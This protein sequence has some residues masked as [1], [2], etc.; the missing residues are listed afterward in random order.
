[1]SIGRTTQGGDVRGLYMF[2]LKDANALISQLTDDDLGTAV[3]VNIATHHFR[4]DYTVRPNVQLQNLLFIQDQ[5]RNSNPAASFFVPLGR[6][7]ART[8]R[9]QGQLAF[10]F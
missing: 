1:M 3:G 2:G 10:S 4:V 6:D 9:Y 8:W 7:A 5:R